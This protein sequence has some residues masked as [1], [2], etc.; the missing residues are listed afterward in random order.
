MKRLMLVVCVF[1][2]F[3]M[4]LQGCDSNKK[5]LEEIEVE[6]VYSLKFR[7]N[8]EEFSGIPETIATPECIYRLDWKSLFDGSAFYDIP[9]ISRIQRDDRKVI[10]VERTDMKMQNFLDMASA[11]AGGILYDQET[12]SVWSWFVVDNKMSL[13][14]YDNKLEMKSSFSVPVKEA[15]SRSMLEPGWIVRKIKNGFLVASS[16]NILKITDDGTVQVDYERK[17]AD[18]VDLC[19]IGEKTMLISEVID[20]YANSGIRF[21]DISDGANPKEL[22][23]ENMKGAAKFTPQTENG[24]ILIETY[25]GKAPA[26]YILNN[27]TMEIDTEIMIDEFNSAYSSYDATMP[28]E[29]D[30]FVYIDERTKDSEA[31]IIKSELYAYRDG[32]V[33]GN[34]SLSTTVEY[35]DS[36]F[37]DGDK[38][39]LCGRTLDGYIVEYSCDIKD[40]V[41]K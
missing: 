40:I 4:L 38:L 30:L 13:T 8:P 6:E 34:V 35:M 11:P 25:G 21:V 1:S 22:K 39:I 15:M 12:G 33:V 36:I 16:Q 18:V 7:E 27:N 28:N 14:E 10:S 37:I 41:N 2:C 31:R 32:E 26:Y 17:N 3:V 24:N 5:V 29:H 20:K 23:K 19:M 9:M